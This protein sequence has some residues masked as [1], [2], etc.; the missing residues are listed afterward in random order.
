[1]QSVTD[2]AP[3]AERLHARK[4]A[5]ALIALRLGCFVAVT[6][7]AAP[8]FAWEHWGGDRGGTRFSALQQIT[9]DNVSRLIRAWQFRTGDLARRDPQTMAWT[10]FEVTPLFVEDRL[11]LCTP[12]NEVIALD[13]AAGT[14]QW[15]FDPKISIERPANRYN[16]RGVAYWVDEQAPSDAACR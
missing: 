14:E 4:T 7:V 1:M 8:A 3:T 15:R 9:S 16:C 12:F 10:K 5:R 6:P 11:I 2:V 13:P